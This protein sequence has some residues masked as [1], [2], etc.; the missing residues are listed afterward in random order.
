MTVNAETA[1]SG[2]Y[3]GNGTTTVFAYDFKALDQ[4]HLVV[5]LTVTATGV[6]TTQTITTHYTVSGVGTDGG[7]NVTMVTAPASTE[8]LTITRAVPQTQTTDLVNRGAVVPTTLETALD[9]GVQQ[10][11]DFNEVTSRTLKVPVSTGSGVS[12]ELPAPTAN[13]V[14]QWDAAGTAMTVGPT[15]T[16]ISAAATNATNAATSATAAAASATTAAASATTALA[17]KITISTASPSGGVD[18]DIWFKV[19]T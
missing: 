9:R 5:T 1:K 8:T 14:L 4:T 15:A 3:T 13:T 7:G 6:E 11:Q 10:V 16:D 12:V 19:S 2:P 17:A 18:G